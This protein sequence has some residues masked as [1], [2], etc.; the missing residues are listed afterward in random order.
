MN[1]C[2]W[3]SLL[4][5]PNTCLAVTLTQALFETLHTLLTAP[6]HCSH[7]QLTNQLGHRE[8]KFP[9]IEG[10]RA[11]GSPQSAQAVWPGVQALYHHAELRHTAILPQG[12]VRLNCADAHKTSYSNKH[13]STQPQ[14]VCGV[15][16]YSVEVKL[17]VC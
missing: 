13:I 10:D 4:Y 1:S 2:K 17:H 3:L 7:S 15:W 16:N 14:S 5:L 9:E 8:S 11:N 12:R 6:K